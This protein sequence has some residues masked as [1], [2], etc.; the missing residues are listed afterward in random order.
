MAQ[1]ITL[2]QLYASQVKS[3]VDNCSMRL[4][5]HGTP[6]LRR[7]MTLPSHGIPNHDFTSL[8][9]YQLM[10]RPT[11]DNTRPW[12]Y[13]SSTLPNPDT[14]M[15]WHYHVMTLTGHDTTRPWH[16]QRNCETDRF[17]SGL[18]FRS[19]LQHKIPLATELRTEVSFSGGGQRK[20]GCSPTA[21]LLLFSEFDRPSVSPMSRVFCRIRFRS[22]S[23]TPEVVSDLVDGPYCCYCCYFRL[24]P[25]IERSSGHSFASRPWLAVAAVYIRLQIF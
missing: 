1:T 13:Q 25:T 23:N 10:T 17:Q 15:S 22:K 9:Y 16:L 11:H 8:W 4:P 2:Y 24:V 7:I 18:N 19:M 14:T 20:G 3:R 6:G 12:H 5:A 21:G